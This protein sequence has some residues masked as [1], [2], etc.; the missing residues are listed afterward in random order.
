RILV[1]EN[2]RVQE[3]G[4]HEELLANNGRYAELFALQAAG[5]R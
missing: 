4:S 5:Y 2:G 1:V 3:I